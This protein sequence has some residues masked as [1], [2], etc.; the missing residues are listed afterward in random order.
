VNNTFVNQFSENIKFN[1]TCFDRIIIRGYIRRF[2]FEACIVLF[3]KAM[4][5][6][7]RTNGVMRIF[8]DQ[9]NSHISKEAAKHDIPILW[10][11][12]ID[13]GKNGAK[14]KYVEKH[15]ANHFKDSGNTV[16]CI[17]TGK[18]PVQTFASRKLTS[19]KGRIFHQIYKCR[20]PVKQY[21]IYFHDSVLG[22]PCYL[23]ISSYLPFH[24]E[25]YFNGHN[26]I[27]ISL[28]QKGISYRMKDNAFVDVSEPEQLQ[29]IANKIQGDLIK[30]RINYWMDRF[31][32]FDKGKYSTRSKYLHHEWYMSQVEVCSNIVFKF[33]GV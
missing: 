22:G 1:Y 27:K 23:K 21:Y 4:G 5:F 16:F 32:R 28:D 30:Q 25:F 29:K 11:P 3:L 7:K 12:S 26:Y 18:E 6:S 9:L 31:F 19:K 2:F 10:W 13:G 24:C 20:K 17:I 14:L 8:T 33:R 15:F